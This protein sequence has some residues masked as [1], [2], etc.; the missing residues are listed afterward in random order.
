MKFFKDETNIGISAPNNK[1][2]NC[3]QINAGSYFTIRIQLF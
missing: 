2:D 3:L 1:M